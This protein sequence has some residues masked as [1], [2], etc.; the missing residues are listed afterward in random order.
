VSLVDAVKSAVCA[1]HTICQALGG[2]R[3]LG[4]IAAR[5]L[6]QH[7]R[8]SVCCALLLH[9]RHDL[10][11]LKAVFINKL[12]SHSGQGNRR[13]VKTAPVPLCNSDLAKLPH[14]AGSTM[15][16]KR[17]SPPCRTR[18]FSYTTHTMQAPR[19][20]RSCCSDDKMLPAL[21]HHA[22]HCLHCGAAG[23]HTFRA[24]APV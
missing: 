20:K 23:R 13:R 3:A 9:A 24:G 6:T 15:T 19:A 17:G 5:F 21:V 14:E 4:A 2:A 8:K 10:A 22:W 18:F 11:S 1:G 7:S 12:V 16:Q